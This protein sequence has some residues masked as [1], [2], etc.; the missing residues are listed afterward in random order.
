M[1][2]RQNETKK[3]ASQTANEKTFQVREFLLFGGL[4]VVHRSEK[5]TSGF[6]APPEPEPDERAAEPLLRA[7]RPA[8]Q[9]ACHSIIRHVS[10]CGVTCKPPYL[11]IDDNLLVNCFL[12]EQY[13]RQG[14]LT[15]RAV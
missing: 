4:Q 11:R 12:Y 8:V 13:L 3:S 1:I 14:D 7:H 2:T 6:Q 10:R 9:G 15:F 5:R